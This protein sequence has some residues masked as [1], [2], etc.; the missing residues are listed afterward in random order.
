MIIRQSLLIIFFTLATCQK[1]YNPQIHRVQLGGGLKYYYY[2]VNIYVGSPPQREALIIDTGS[3]KTIFPCVDCQNNNCGSHLNKYF[4]YKSSSTFH[5]LKCQ[6]KFENFQCFCNSQDQDQINQCTFVQDYMEGSSYKGY[7]MIDQAIFG[8]ELYQAYRN[9]TLIETLIKEK[10]I[11]I[12]TQ[13]MF[14][15]ATIETKLFKTQD[16]DGI[17]GLGPETNQ[18]NTQPNLIDMA[19][20]THNHI[21]EKLEFSLCLGIDSG[22]MQI[23]GYDTQNHLNNGNN[24]KIKYDTNLVNE[25]YG[26]KIHKLQIGNQTLDDDF[27]TFIDSGTTYTYFP[28]K[29]YN[30]IMNQ[31][32]EHCKDPQNCLGDMIKDKCYLYNKTKTNIT[33]EQFFDSF[34][35]IKLQLDDDQIFEWPSM[36]Y[37][38]ETKQYKFCISIES[39]SATL[40]QTFMRY[41]D[42]LFDR[43][44]KQIQINQAFCSEYVFGDKEIHNISIDEDP[45]PINETVQQNDYIILAIIVIVGILALAVLVFLGI[46]KCKKHQELPSDEKIMIKKENDD[47]NKGIQKGNNDIEKQ[48]GNKFQIGDNEDQN[49]E[50]AYKDIYQEK[51]DEE[52]NS[53]V[54]Q[55]LAEFQKFNFETN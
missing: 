52:D 8:D 31:I 51:L 20:R 1:E 18:Q 4:D 9:E 14:G 40:G 41:N 19:F 49:I 47:Q 11:D 35:T 48:K 22:Y 44:S 37:M 55:Q 28:N 38:Y 13:F 36:Y 32:N 10:Y 43:E 3:T 39:G 26:I 34:P 45:K 27:A 53:K 15:C 24:I 25:Q 6:E 17:L 16:A 2:Y 29:Y 12:Q 42:I 7:Y 30:F 21:S 50:M 54:K 5:P 23:G 33:I 46:K